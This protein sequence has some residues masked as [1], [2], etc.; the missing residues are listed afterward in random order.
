MGSWGSAGLE[1][2]RKA[3]RSA[4]RA[5]WGT[6]EP[7][8]LYLSPW[9]TLNDT[10]SLW[11][12][13]TWNHSG[14]AILRNTDP[15][16]IRLTGEQSSTMGEGSCSLNVAGRIVSSGCKTAGP[17][18]ESLHSSCMTPRTVPSSEMVRGGGLE[19]LLH[20]V[21]ISSQEKARLEFPSWC[22]G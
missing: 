22:S 11:A 8:S 12:T 4:Q 7:G 20:P 3:G 16:R 21:S 13:L 9:Q 14:K 17:M 10:A 19:P 5:E 2:R 6:L 1:F 15:R 18:K